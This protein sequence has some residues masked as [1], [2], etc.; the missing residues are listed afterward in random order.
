MSRRLNFTAMTAAVA[1]VFTVVLGGCAAVPTGGT[2]G[3]AFCDV[4]RA[5][6]PAA[7]DIDR[8][9]IAL[10]RQLASHNR[11]GEQN[12]GWTP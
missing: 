5:I 9:S 8:V 2:R 1:L 10:G 7:A 11:F 6:R 12:C 4:A 3:G